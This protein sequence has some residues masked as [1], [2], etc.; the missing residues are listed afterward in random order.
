MDYSINTV[1][2]CAHDLPFNYRHA[3]RLTDIEGVAELLRE[4]QLVNATVEAVVSDRLRSIAEH[5]IS[6]SEG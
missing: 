6:Y 2:R 1:L 4:G 3:L 5:R